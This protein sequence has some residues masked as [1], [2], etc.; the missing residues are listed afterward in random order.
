[1]P[2][3]WVGLEEKNSLLLF[4]LRDTKRKE[5][6]PE[7]ISKSQARTPEKQPSPSVSFV[8]QEVDLGPFLLPLSPCRGGGRGRQG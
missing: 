7:V 4:F 8:H 2:C 1:M 3:Q 5:E 6:Q